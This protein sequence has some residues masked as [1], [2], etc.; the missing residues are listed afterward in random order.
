[1]RLESGVTLKSQL[2]N[3]YP[4]STGQCWC[5]W[6]QGQIILTA[7]RQAP[8]FQTIGIIL[9]STTYQVTNCQIS[10]VKTISSS[11]RAM[12]PIIYSDILRLL[13]TFHN[14]KNTRVIYS[15]VKHI[16]F[17]TWFTQFNIWL[18][19]K[20]VW[21][22]LYILKWIELK[23]PP[24]KGYIIKCRHVIFVETDIISSRTA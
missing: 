24:L 4:I 13:L 2:D 16:I 11:S 15:K 5:Q 7:W 3:P 17:N 19:S 20:C 8:C 1:M 14:F 10:T 23:F 18:I 6:I 22:R 9:S 21:K 12:R